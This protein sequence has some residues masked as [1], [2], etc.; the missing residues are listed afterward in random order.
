MYPHQHE[1]L[2][3][4]LTREGLEALVATTPANIAY[5]T[6]FRSLSQAIYS[7]TPMFA[8][9]TGRGTAL[10]VPVIEVA[11]VAAEA[12]AVDHV[13]SYGEFY[14]DHVERAGDLG[15]RIRSW[16]DAPRSGAADALAV[17]LER[18]DVRRGPIGLDDGSLVFDAWH[19]ASE[20]LAPLKVLAAGSLFAQ[21]R[22][23][24]GPYEIECLERALHVAEEALDNVIQ[25]IQPGMTERAAMTLFDETVV[26]KGGTPLVTIVAFGERSAIPPPYPADRALR[27]RELVRFEVGCVVRGHCATV[28]RTAVMGQ[29]DEQQERTY[30]AIAAGVETAIRAIRPGV[31]AGR[32]FDATVAAVREAG[33]PGY[34]RHHVGHAI[35][36]EPFETPLLA[37]GDDTELAQAMVLRV[38]TPYYL[39]G[40]GG[41]T[42]METLLVTRDGARVMNRSARGL[43]AL[44]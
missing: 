18:L 6:G 43:V 20:R 35:G 4:V 12:P 31:T 27:P 41:V 16:S 11:A 19:R 7:R 30:D 1:R 15:R 5:L 9:V 23:V 3:E 33:L 42:V 44:D 29:P 22:M 38:E 25:A 13:V 36:L 28:A 26:R 39:V 14:L 32:V 17:A 10:V 8:I 37:A 21:A 34:R 40:W 24:K 2:T